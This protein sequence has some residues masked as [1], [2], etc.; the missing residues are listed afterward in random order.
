[1]MSRDFN[2]GEVDEEDLMDE[3]NDLD[4]ELAMEEMSAGKGH[5]AKINTGGT[6]VP[7]NEEDQLNELMN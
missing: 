6:T 2:V 1:M 4:E 3:L 7:A 5:G